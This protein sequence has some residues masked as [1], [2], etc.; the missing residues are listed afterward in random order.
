MFGMGFIWPGVYFE[1]SAISSISRETTVHM[2]TE[3][4]EKCLFPTAG[5]I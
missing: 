1:P 4:S 3:S 5:T 2:I